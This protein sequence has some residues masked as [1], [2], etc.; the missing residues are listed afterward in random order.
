MRPVARRGL[1]GARPRRRPARGGALEGAGVAMSRRRAIAPCASEP[2]KPARGPMQ[3]AGGAQVYSDSI[4][5]GTSP[6]ARRVF[7]FIRVVGRAVRHKG[8]SHALR[9]PRLR[10]FVRASL[11]SP[12]A[13][14]RAGV[15]SCTHRRAAQ[16][17]RRAYCPFPFPL[18]WFSSLAF[19]D[20]PAFT[21]R[22]NPYTQASTGTHLHTPPLHPLKA[23]HP[24]P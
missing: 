8:S 12:P 5:E 13:R 11:S 18:Q 19:S 21:R 10:L 9:C 7:S 15:I 3:H 20:S 16:Q 1:E 14:A 23:S 17:A 2:T 24:G 22:I 6:P 4:P